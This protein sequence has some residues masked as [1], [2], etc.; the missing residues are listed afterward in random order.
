MLKKEKPEY[1]I[2]H[3]VTILPLII[4]LLSNHKTKFILR[5]SGLP[6]I[7]FLR[8]ILW[9]KASNKLFLITCPSE[10]TKVDM[11]QLGL[12]PEKKIKVLYDPILEFELISE[13]LKKKYELNKKNKKY[14]LNIGRLT[15]Q[16]N[17]ALLIKAFKDLTK[18]YQDLH[19]YI[20]GDGEEKRN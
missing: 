3:L 1:F 13:K 16:K 19:L 20:V 11:V 6:K 18:N 12:F 4:L 5:I 15:K 7:T 14:F 17:Q 9:K 8:K 10:Q 2:L